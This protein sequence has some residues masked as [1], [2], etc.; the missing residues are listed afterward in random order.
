MRGWKS[1]VFLVTSL[2]LATLAKPAQADSID[3][4]WCSQEGKRITIAGPAIVT[5]GG[6]RMMGDYNRHYFSYVIPPS[7]PNAGATVLM[8][9]MGEELVH[10]RTGADPTQ[11]ATATAVAWRRC[12][13]SISLLQRSNNQ[14]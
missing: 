5:P 7:E 1:I 9:L 6:T 14:A 12:G 8:T 4:N 10:I 2:L 3:G 11:A 13:P